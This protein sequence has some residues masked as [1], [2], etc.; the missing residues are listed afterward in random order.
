MDVLKYLEALKG[1]KEDLSPESLDMI[2][3][4]SISNFLIHYD[5]LKGFE[6]SIVEKLVKD[7]FDDASSQN[8][9]VDK[10]YSRMLYRKYIIRIGQYYSSQLRFRIAIELD[11]AIFVGVIFDVGL[12]LTGLSQRIYYIPIVTI[13]AISYS[14]YLFFFFGLKKKLYGPKY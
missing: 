5:E 3:F 11:V 4:R 2:H 7:Y 8:Y 13:I 10:E 12:L 9:L 6:R 1:L 14:R